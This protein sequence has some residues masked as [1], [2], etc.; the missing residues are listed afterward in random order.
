[1][2]NLRSDIELAALAALMPSCVGLLE[3][4]LHPQVAYNFWL[5]NGHHHAHTSTLE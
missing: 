4:A 2:I 5:L 1:M 3:R